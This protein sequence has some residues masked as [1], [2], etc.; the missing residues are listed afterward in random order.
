[1]TRAREE[2]EA[3]AGRPVGEVTAA[4][5]R[6]PDADVLVGTEA[7]LHRLSPADGFGAVA[8]VDFDQE[9]LA[10][11]V[12][13]GEEALALLAHASR[14]VGGRP[15]P[16]PGPDPPARP[17]RGPGRPAGRPRPADRGRAGGAAA[18]CACRR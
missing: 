3:L 14:L 10:P 17:S 8:F 4:T 2:L 16:G 1:M 11:R 13:A 12:R 9:L 18:P 6:L 15:G 7:V 5:G